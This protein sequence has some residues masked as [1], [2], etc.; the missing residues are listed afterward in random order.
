MNK[1]L[2]FCFSNYTKNH[3]EVQDMIG[4]IMQPL[5]NEL[6]R[7]IGAEKY[8][9]IHDIISERAFKLSEYSGAVGMSVALAVVDG[10]I[11]TKEIIE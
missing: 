7:L 4:E 3:E 10:T 8:D 1:F 11:D 5:H 2:R 9:Y 6:E